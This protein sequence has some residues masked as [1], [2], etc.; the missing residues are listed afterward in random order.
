[1]SGDQG[2]QPVGDDDRPLRAVLGRSRFGGAV[3][4]ALDLTADHHPTAEEVDVADL[5][6]SRLAEPEA[7][8]RADGDEGGEPLVG[9]R[10][11]CADLGR[12]GDGHGVLVTPAAGECHPIAGVGGDHPV[13]DGA[14]QHGPHVLHPGVHGARG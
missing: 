12:C 1:V 8:E 10:E 2:E 14:A 3:G 11:Q 5:Q 13:A 7:A 6:G 4:S 9:G